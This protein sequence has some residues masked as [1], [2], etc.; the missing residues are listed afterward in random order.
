M[1]VP[2][3]DAGDT[4]CDDALVSAGLLRWDNTDDRDDLFAELFVFPWVDDILFSKLFFFHSGLQV[5]LA[6]DA[7]DGLGVVGE[8]GGVVLVLV[9]DVGDVDVLAPS[10]LAP[11]C[12]APPCAPTAPLTRTWW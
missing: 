4:F 11:P 9:G 2:D 7:E 1:L 5:N 8:P 6:P 10:P 3:A 12:W